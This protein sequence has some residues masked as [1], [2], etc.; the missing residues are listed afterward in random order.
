[1]KNA[2][3]VILALGVIGLG[4]NAARNTQVLTFESLRGE[5]KEVIRG[6]VTVPISA[7]GPVGPANRYPIKSKA[8]G[9][10]IEI[11]YEPGEVVKKGDLL[12]RLDRDQEQRSV[13]RAEAEVERGAATLE[14]S[15]I[16]LERLQTIGKD[17][18]QS[19]VDQLTPQLE[20]TKFL[21]DKT[22][23][24][25][26]EGRT[27]TEEL[28]RFRSNHEELKARLASA[29]LDVNDIDTQIKSTRQE[30]V[31]QE[32]IHHQGLAS[33]GDAR[34]RLSE[35]EIY[36]PVDGMVVSIETQVGAVI[37]GGATTFTGGTVLVVVA[38]VA[39]RY[40]RAEVDEADVGEV[41]NLAADWAKPGYNRPSEHPIPIAEQTPVTIRVDAFHGEEFTGII[42]RIHPEP[43]STINR[44]VTYQVDILLT[45]ANSDKLLTGML[46]DVEFT[47]QSALNVLLVPHEAIHLDEF[48]EMGVYVP[49]EKPQPD[50]DEYKFIRCRF[51]V[52]NGMYAEVTEGLSEGMKVYTT[53]PKKLGRDRA[54]DGE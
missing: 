44:V 32:A 15:R 22:E 12:V 9:E 41:R 1:M 20:Y 30:I 43:N 49:V 54:K 46:A 16:K 28:L 2:I 26:A 21:R 37:Q 24:L 51:G 27:S 35:T 4:Y 48:E 38:D 36:S 47:A 10:V 3:L 17:K 13:G 31:L 39:K 33:L 52:D 45:S 5:T 34:E 53:L 11:L 40:V 6:D 8:S 29:V 50:E 19:L 23:A 25:A 14:M 18:A 7:S 42:E